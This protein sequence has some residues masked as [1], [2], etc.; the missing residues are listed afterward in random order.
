MW[1]PGCSNINALA[2]CLFQVRNKRKY[3]ITVVLRSSRKKGRMSA[4][5]ENIWRLINYGCES[6]SRTK[7]KRKKPP[8]RPR[9]RLM[10]H[11]GDWLVINRREKPVYI[12]T[13]IHPDSR[14][15]WWISGASLK[16][17]PGSG[18]HCEGGSPLNQLIKC[19][20]RCNR[21]DVRLLFCTSH[22]KQIW[23]IDTQMQ[24]ICTTEHNTNGVSSV[25]L[26]NIWSNVKVH[27]LEMYYV[28]MMGWAGAFNSLINN[29][30][31]R[32]LNQ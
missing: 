29:F 27:K 18:P 22:N 20:S 4:C 23:I 21:L 15:S 31:L 14:S 16:I 19:W 12:S 17:K 1:H 30:F 7:K 5:Q 25:S 3:T 28:D 2:C 13:G 6:F 24:F 10:C 9:E 26:T 8:P 11:V 32:V